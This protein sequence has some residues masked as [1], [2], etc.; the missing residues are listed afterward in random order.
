MI[1]PLLMNPPMCSLK[2][3]KD[4]TYTIYDLEM[5]HQISE[6]KSHTYAVA[7]PTTPAA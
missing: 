1:T 4:G 3:L 6:I 7:G 2:E 5:M